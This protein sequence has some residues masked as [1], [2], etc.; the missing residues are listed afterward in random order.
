MHEVFEDPDMHQVFE[1]LDKF[2][3]NPYTE[4]DQLVPAG[5]LLDPAANEFKGSQLTLQGT[6]T[7]TQP[8]RGC[9]CARAPFESNSCNSLHSACACQLRVQGYH[10]HARACAALI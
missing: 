10:M 9:H 4:D 6:C 2:M 1:W 7:H 8:G 3:R 5:Q